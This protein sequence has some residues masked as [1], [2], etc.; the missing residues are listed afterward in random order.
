MIDS[1]AD[2]ATLNTKQ[3]TNRIKRQEYKD[4]QKVQY[5]FIGG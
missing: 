1:A 4:E 2:F 3:L 5:G